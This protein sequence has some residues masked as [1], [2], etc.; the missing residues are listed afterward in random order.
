MGC[1]HRVAGSL[2]RHGGLGS[3]WA[4]TVCHSSRIGWCLCPCIGICLRPRP[5]RCLSVCGS[6]GWDQ[7]DGRSSCPRTALSH[8]FRAGLC[9]GRCM[10][11]RLCLSERLVWGLG[12]SCG[13]RLFYGYNIIDSHTAISP[14]R[15][16]RGGRV[17]KKIEAVE[18]PLASFYRGCDGVLLMDDQD[19]SGN[20]DMDY[21]C[22][23]GGNRS[24][25]V[26]RD[27]ESTAG[28]GGED[29]CDTP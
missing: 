2:S 16:C 13:V 27:Q 6:L 23:W 14:E 3:T 9:D 24:R 12:W 26:K 25:G 5:A 29:L 18:L 11:W 20:L 7:G 8:R 28:C 10:G 1:G 22:S 17:S 19:I 21:I 15:Q 4:L